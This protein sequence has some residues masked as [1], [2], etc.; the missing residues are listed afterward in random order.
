MAAQAADFRV[1]QGALEQLCKH[2]A[3]WLFQAPPAT[4]T[5]TQHITEARERAQ[6]GQHA[7][8][9]SSAAA[10]DMYLHTAPTNC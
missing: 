9:R 7:Q 5:Y 4:G 10:L 1:D 6:C 8:V 3:Q 2:V